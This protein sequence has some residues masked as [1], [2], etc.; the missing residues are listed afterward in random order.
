MAVSGVGAQGGKVVVVNS[1][2]LEAIGT[3]A[4][5]TGAEVK[6]LQFSPSGKTLVAASKLGQSPLSVSLFLCVSLDVSLSHCRLQCV[7][8]QT[9]TLCLE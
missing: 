4:L 8:Q 2:N 6:E 1:Y 9:D 5:G 3:V 7:T